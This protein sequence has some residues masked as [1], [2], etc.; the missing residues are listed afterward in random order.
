MEKLNARLKIASMKRTKI[1]YVKIVGAGLA[2]TEAALYLAKKGISVK[3]YDIKPNN[4]TPAHKSP[5]YAELVCSNS[6]KSNDVYGNAAGLLKEEMRLLGS[7][8]IAVAD[9][10]RVPAGNALAVNREEFA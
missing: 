3:L 4:F 7:E 8:I 6:L 2:G 1:N 10:T 5:K 9:S